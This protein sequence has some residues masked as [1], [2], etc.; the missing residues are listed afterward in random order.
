MSEIETFIVTGGAGFI[1]VNLCS[2]LLNQGHYVICIDNL[3]SGQISNIEQ[4]FTAYKDSFLW[5][6]SDVENVDIDLI[7]K[8]INRN[9]NGIY[10]LA[11]PASPVFYQK[12]PIKTMT[13]NVFGTHRILNL[14]ID[15]QCRI[16]I[17]STSE[18]YGNPTENPQKEEYNGNV[19]ITG[20]RS[21]Y[22]E[23]KR[24]SETLTM[25][26]IRKKN[27]NGIIVRIFN[28]YGPNMRRDDGRVISNFIVQA[29]QNKSL[30]I[31]GNG[32]QTRSFCYIDDLVEGLISG[33]NHKIYGPINLGN[34][35]EYKISDI[36]KKVIDLTQSGSLTVCLPLPEDDPVLRCPDITRAKKNLK[37]TPKTSV[38]EG[39]E[40]TIE[41]FKNYI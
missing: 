16:L 31:Y 4:F 33:M 6:E 27:L 2:K 41:Y 13:T 30:T 15:C 14:A 21:C 38:K 11:C 35:E 8:R 39:L 17:A 18:V 34:P 29:L 26:Y 36:A 37:W 25:D 20:I 23:G 5:I 3:Y 7:K 10:H 40:K 1:G 24:A 22:D 28:T 12:D 32:N 9:V 19:N